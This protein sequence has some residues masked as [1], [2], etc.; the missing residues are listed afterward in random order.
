MMHGRK[1]IKLKICFCHLKNNLP[2]STEDVKIKFIKMARTFF[3]TE[4]NNLGQKP[5]HFN[6]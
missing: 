1:N 4:A 3:N 6:V 2:D 5:K